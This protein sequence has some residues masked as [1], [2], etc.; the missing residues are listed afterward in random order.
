MALPAT[1][2]MKFLRGDTQSFTITLTENGTT[3]RDLSGCTYR[4]QIRTSKNAPTIAGQFTCTVPTPSNG[5]VNLL[6]TA[7]ESALL[8]E[9]VLYWD[10]EQT[11]DGI[12]TTILAGKCT[13]VGD[14]T[15]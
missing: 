4:A 10:F 3:P 14:V 13:I 7:S 11:K 9:A 2:N 5:V 8:P 15:K 12:V 6:L 1:R